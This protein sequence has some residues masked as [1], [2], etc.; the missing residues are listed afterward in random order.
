MLTA[1]LKRA[2][3]Q[4][5]L[6][7]LAASPNREMSAATIQEVVPDYL[8]GPAMNAYFKLPAE[9]RE[10]LVARVFPEDQCI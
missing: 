4:I 2:W 8:N 10:A 7:L 6:G 5:G 3:G 1:A 9:E